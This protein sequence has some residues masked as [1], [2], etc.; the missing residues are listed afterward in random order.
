[1]QK[2]NAVGLSRKDASIRMLN[3]ESAELKATL[4]KLMPTVNAMENQLNTVT[5]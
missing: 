5:L 1:M 2:V 3:E 4:D